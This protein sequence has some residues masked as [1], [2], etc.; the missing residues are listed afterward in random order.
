MLQFIVYNAKSQNLQ[1]WPGWPILKWVLAATVCS[2]MY[3][4]LYVA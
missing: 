1:L 2:R 3:C 4:S